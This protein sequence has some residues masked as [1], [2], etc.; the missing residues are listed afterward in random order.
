MQPQRGWVPA[1]GEGDLE[2]A[3]GSRGEDAEQHGALAILTLV[4]L[5]RVA[6][7]LKSRSTAFSR[8]AEGAPLVLVEHGKPL[9]ERLRKE[10]ISTDDILASARK[11][12]GL[13]R[14]DQIEYAVLESSG[15]ISII[16]KKSQ[17]EREKDLEESRRI[18]GE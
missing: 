8:L 13:L 3:A 5:D 17:Q 4:V 1:A 6:D 10:H 18:G 14:L 9:Q 16:P 15:G 12:Q 7:M 11:S 2:P